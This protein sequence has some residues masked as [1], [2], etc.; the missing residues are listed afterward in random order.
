[1]TTPTRLICWLRG[2]QMAFDDTR[3]VL[4]DGLLDVT[5]FCTRCGKVLAEWT[6]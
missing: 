6:E 1:M 3:S 2:H 5:S 4:C